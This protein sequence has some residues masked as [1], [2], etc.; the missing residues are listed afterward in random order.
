M[1]QAPA[2]AK[3]LGLLG[4]LKQQ[5]PDPDFEGC[6]EIL[7]QLAINSHE[8][9]PCRVTDLVQSMRFGTGPTVHRKVGVLVERRFIEVSADP[10]DARAKL[11][12]ITSKGIDYLKEKSKLMKL[13]V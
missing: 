9:N 7:A 5:N 12:T 11:L 6:E 2:Y 1:T 8:S 13:C 3:F 10:T 4:N